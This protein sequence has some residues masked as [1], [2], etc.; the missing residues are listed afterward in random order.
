MRKIRAVLYAISKC[1][2]EWEVVI[3]VAFSK[4]WRFGCRSS[5]NG[6]CGCRSCA[7]GGGCRWEGCRSGNSCSGCRHF[8]RSYTVNTPSTDIIKP[9]ALILTGIDVEKHVDF[10]VQLNVELTDF[11]LT[12]HIE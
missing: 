12:K 11:F 4:R 9:T 2:L 10:L 7:I 5:S 8:A 6:W 1:A 3:A